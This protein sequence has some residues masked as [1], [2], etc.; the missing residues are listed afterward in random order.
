[1]RRDQEA[2]QVSLTLES[3]SVR[4]VIGGGENAEVGTGSLP[5]DPGGTCDAEEAG[6]KIKHSPGG[7]VES[8][9]PEPKQWITGD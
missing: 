2:L 4:P 8:K 7:G 1:M 5:T 3:T 6:Y 9:H